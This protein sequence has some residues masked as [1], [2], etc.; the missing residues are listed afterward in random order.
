MFTF[1]LIALSW[2]KFKKFSLKSGFTYDKIC[3]GFHEKPIWGHRRNVDSDARVAMNSIL[4]PL[5]FCGRERI[6]RQFF[7][8]E[9]YIKHA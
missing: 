8:N 2:R 9:Y 5:D 4:H 6:C 7:K 3:H 1:F